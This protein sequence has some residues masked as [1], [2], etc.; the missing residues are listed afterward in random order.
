MLSSLKNWAIEKVVSAY[1]ATNGWKTITGYVA[2]M[3][4]AYLASRYPFL[5]QDIYFQ[6]IQGAMQALLA[7][8]VLDKLRKNLTQTTVVK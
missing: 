2:T 4:A 7:A 3:G 8:G 6:V 5:S 1:I